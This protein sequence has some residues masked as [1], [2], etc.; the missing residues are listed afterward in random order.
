MS[1]ALTLI[2]AVQASAEPAEASAFEARYAALAENNF[3]RRDR[4][5][6]PEPEPAPPAPPPPPPPPPETNWR[7]TGVVFEKGVFRGYFEDRQTGQ[8]LNLPAGG[9]I[10]RGVVGE[11]YIDGVGYVR[12]GQTQWVDV[13]DDLT[14]EP[15]DPPVA[16]DSPDAPANPLADGGENAGEMSVAERMRLRREREQGGPP[17]NRGRDGPGRWQGRGPPDD[18]DRRQGDADQNAQREEDDDASE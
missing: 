2:L 1:L 11:L 12:D 4:R 14:G 8:S 5:P 17:E 13:G 18:D 16:A 7:L 6:R 15:A 10:A 3:F 9:Q